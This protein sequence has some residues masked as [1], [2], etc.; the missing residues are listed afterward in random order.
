MTLLSQLP[1]PHR[2]VLLLHYVEDFSLE[3]IAVITE[4]QIGTIKSRLHYARKT[5]RRLL[6]DQ[7]Y[8]D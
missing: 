3:E 2:S 7:P 5:L 1:P 4:V 6:D 8:A